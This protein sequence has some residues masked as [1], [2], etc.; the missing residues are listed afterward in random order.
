VDSVRGR[1]GPCREP[2][3][4][5]RCGNRQIDV[6]NSQRTERRL[7]DLKIDMLV[8]GSGVSGAGVQGDDLLITTFF[9]TSALSV[10][11]IGLDLAPSDVGQDRWRRPLMLGLFGVA[12]LFLVAGLYWWLLRD[13]SSRITAILQQVATSRVSWIT[14]VIGA[15]VWFGRRKI[16]ALLASVNGSPLLSRIPPL[17]FVA[18]IAAGGV[19]IAVVA[20]LSPTKPD[21]VSPHTIGPGFTFSVLDALQAQQPARELDVPGGWNVL[22]TGPP[23]SD[24]AKGAL[25]IILPRGLKK[26][27]FLESPHYERD[28]DA[29][30]IPDPQFSGIV[31]QGNNAL[32]RALLAALTDATCFPIKTTQGQGTYERLEKYYQVPNFLWIQFGKGSPWSNPLACAG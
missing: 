2:Q 17:L 12:A 23:E 11:K 20:L 24:T 7:D 18:I 5:P 22:M 16:L 15:L 1:R 29:P 13:P 21:T 32:N 14:L 4:C 8:M 26:V 3:V 30:P 25:R 6:V 31:L 9:I 19:A 28:L 10:F 27:N